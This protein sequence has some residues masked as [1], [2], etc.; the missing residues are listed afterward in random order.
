MFTTFMYAKQSYE[1]FRKAVLAHP[2]VAELMPW[3]LDDLKQL[4]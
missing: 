2:A 4:T 1:L 3:I